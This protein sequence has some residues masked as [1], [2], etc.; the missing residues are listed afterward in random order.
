MMWMLIF[1]VFEIKWMTLFTNGSSILVKTQLLGSNSLNSLYLPMSSKAQIPC[2][3]IAEEWGQHTVE[4][5]PPSNNNLTRGTGYAIA[6][7]NCLKN[8]ENLIW[9][10]TGQGG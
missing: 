3:F 2:L 10:S 9:K 5:S 4:T 7:W 8:E 1:N 6:A